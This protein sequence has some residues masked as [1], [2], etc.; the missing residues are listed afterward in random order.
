MDKFTKMQNELA[1]RSKN[2]FRDEDPI[3]DKDR[4]LPAVPVKEE[5]P[6]N[7][8]SRDMQAVLGDKRPPTDISSQDDKEIRL[9]NY[10]SKQVRT[11]IING[12]PWWVA[13]DVCEILELSN[14]SMTVSRL[15]E[16]ERG[17]SN[18]Y[19]LG[20]EQ[21]MSI[22]NE[23]GLYS[24]VLRS[25]KPEAKKFKKWITSEVLPSIRKTG[26]YEVKKDPMA[27]LADA[28]LLANEIIKEKELEL[29]ESQRQLEEQAP[30]VEQANAIINCKEGVHISTIAKTLNPVTGQ[31]RL[32]KWLRE[33]GIIYQGS[34]EPKQEY[35]DK[36]Y[37]ILQP[38][39]W[40]DSSGSKHVHY[41]TLVTGAGLFFIQ[42]LWAEYHKAKG[43]G[44]ISKTSPVPM[45]DTEIN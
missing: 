34:T 45:F 23:S 31:N 41:T 9:F 25:N 13:K 28:V 27:K 32:Y 15:D 26:K 40:T 10:D 35:I 14:V 43:E 8:N 19:T 30:V 20:G 1:A 5:N 2:R 36:G 29:L 4:N 38:N 44:H 17:I 11:V 33:Q 16:D 37:F 24:L 42:G 39:E 21:N 3:F 6:F 18:T 22:I 12:E 7:R